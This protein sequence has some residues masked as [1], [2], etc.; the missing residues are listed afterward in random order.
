[1]I[2]KLDAKPSGIFLA[3]DF[4][5]NSFVTSVSGRDVI[6]GSG[7]MVRVVYGAVNVRI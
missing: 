3:M 6:E 4:R 5:C 7:F 2:L 1:M